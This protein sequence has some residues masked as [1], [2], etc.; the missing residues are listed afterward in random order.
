MNQ[1]MPFNKGGM[2]I[3]VQVFAKLHL[4]L[5]TKPTSFLSPPLM[6]VAAVHIHGQL[7]QRTNRHVVWLLDNVDDLPQLPSHMFILNGD[8]T[9]LEEGPVPDDRLGPSWHPWLVR[10]NHIV[11]LQSVLDVVSCPW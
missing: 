9:T 8:G 10:Q 4:N 7:F 5:L 3:A 1:T 2:S 6:H 11:L